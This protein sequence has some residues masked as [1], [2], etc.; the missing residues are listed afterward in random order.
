MKNVIVGTAGHIDHGKTSLVRAL[1][2]IDTDR[3]EEEKRRGIS[4][5]L[6][7]AHLD[8]T[9]DIRIAFVDVP[10][11]EKFIKNM[12]AGAAG[13]DSVMFII[14]ADESI[15]PQTREHFEI[16][17]LLNIRSGVIVLTKS[18]LVDRDILD[19]VRLEVEEF[20]AGSFLDGAPV[21]AVSSTTGEGLAD[22]RAALAATASEVHVKDATRH[23][24]LPIDRSFTMRGFGTVVTG[25]L[26]SGR[27]TVEQE[28]EVHPAAKR[29]RV[30][31]LQVHGAA[32][33]QATAGQRTAVNVAGADHTELARGMILT[34]PGLFRPTTVVDCRFELVGGAKPLKQRAP[35]HFHAGTAEVEAEVRLLS[36]AAVMDPGNADFVR[37]LLRDPLLLLPGDRFIA[38]MF[39]PVVTIGGGVVIDIAPPKRVKRSEAPARLHVLL[40]GSQRD[41]LALL[42]KESKFGVSAAELVAR[43]GWTLNEIEAAAAGV[44][45]VRDP[46]TWF[47]DAD[48]ASSM[49]AKLRSVLAAY[50]K[51]NP[52]QPGIPK[53]ELRSREL[54]RAPAFLLDALLKQEKTLVVTGDVVHLNSHKIAFK[55]DEDTALSRIEHAFEAAGLAVPATHEVLGASGVDAARAKTLLQILVKDKRLVRIGDDLVF[56]PAALRALREKLAAHKGER[57]A[58]PVFKEWTGVSRKYAI[59]LLEFLDREHVTRREG[60]ERI[61]L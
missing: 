42:V 44:V 4:I 51:Q 26:V 23:L 19:L 45:V 7:F 21:V 34:E 56:H 46:Q 53:E 31:G 38:R 48:W 39:S 16:C 54:P 58:V 20:V 52:L 37:F 32:A 30:R 12:L 50:H 28:L 57:F 10:G 27:I 36:G 18:D 15:K 43:T 17:R 25:T 14:A 24:R 29:L 6:G 41:Q 33:K 8:L 49:R 5:D 60:D 59:P 61:V 55:Q 47:L 1:T 40:D 35:V 9:P 2:G 13:I 11:H 3:L 22:L